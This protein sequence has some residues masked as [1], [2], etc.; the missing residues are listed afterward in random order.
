METRI[1][2]LTHI[3]DR[4]LSM[5]PGAVLTAI[6]FSD[7]GSVDAINKALSRLQADGVIR[8]IGQGIYDKPEYSS[9][10]KEYS[11]PR[12][13]YVA[14]AL[15]RKF[16]WTIAPSGETALNLFHL[17]TQVPNVW[18]YI[19]DGPYRQYQIGSA[20]LSFRHRANRNTSGMSTITVAAIEAVR[21]FG[22]EKMDDVAVKKMSASLSEQD[23][24][25]LLT[26][27]RNVTDWIKKIIIRICEE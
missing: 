16:N 27:G 2:C 7:L 18:E 24:K 1:K 10:L 22:Q 15:A 17:S 4:I 8:R 3:H 20:T 19:S 13:D 5:E 25:I 21:T 11:A 12:L 9:L 14:A 6:D 23:K 26:E